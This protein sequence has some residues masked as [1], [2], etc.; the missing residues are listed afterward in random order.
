L[1]QERIS[2]TLSANFLLLQRGK[3]GQWEGKMGTLYNHPLSGMLYSKIIKQHNHTC[4]ITRTNQDTKE[5]ENNG[6]A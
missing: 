3:Q 1:K 2:L 4:L 6:I 5:N